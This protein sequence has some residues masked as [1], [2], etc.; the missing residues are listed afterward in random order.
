MTW[1]RAPDRRVAGFTTTLEPVEIVRALDRPDNEWSAD[2]RLA[3]VGSDRLVVEDAA[4]PAV[5]LVV[6]LDE[7]VSG[8]CRITCRAGRRFA[9]AARQR[10]AEIVADLER[11]IRAVER[12][13]DAGAP[14]AAPAPAAPATPYARTGW[15][16]P[17]P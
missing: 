4:D 15:L 8:G 5:S 12:G 13:E 6:L 11:A 2:V 17:A 3:A 7:R 9:P 10:L 1:V 14:S 16:P